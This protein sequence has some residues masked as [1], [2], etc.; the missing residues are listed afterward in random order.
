[1]TKTMKEL[2]PKSLHRVFILR[3]VTDSARLKLE[4]QCTWRNIGEKNSIIDYRDSTNDVYFLITG[5][6]RVI[7]YSASGRAV[8][9][10]DLGPGDVF[11]EFA[12][13]DGRLRSATVEAIE[14]CFLAIIRATDFREV[15]AR[16]PSIMAAILEHAIAQIRS[17]TER[18]YEF[19]TLAVNNRIQAELLR[20]AQHG[21]I[22]AGVTKLT[23]APT[24]LEIASRISTHR[25]AVSRELSRLARLGLIERQG[26]A[27]VI[28]DMKRLA[29]MVHEAVDE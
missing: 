18:I 6:A 5:R 4:R 9:F 19:S 13:I 22:Q 10:R 16:E 21:Q 26:P 1:M 12:A 7:I 14:P 27:L 3:N 25:E 29:R 28:K 24:H 15:L 2:A 20:L 17:L 23:P 11:G 8:A